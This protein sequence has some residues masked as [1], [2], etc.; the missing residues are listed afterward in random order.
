MPSVCLDI[1]DLGLI[2]YNKFL[3][4][5]EDI[6]G[7]RSVVEGE[8]CVVFFAEHPM[9]ITIGRKPSGKMF[10]GDSNIDLVKVSRGGSIT[11]HFPG[12]LMLYVIFNMKKVGVGLRQWMQGLEDIVCEG[13]VGLGAQGIERRNRGLWLGKGKIA[14]FGVGVKNWVTRFGCGV[15]YRL[16]NRINEVIYPCGEEGFFDSINRC[17]TGISR[18]D[19][20]KALRDQ[21]EA[22]FKKQ[23]EGGCF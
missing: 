19:L 15:T 14:S 18:D 12:Q 10:K 5:Q 9:V 21:V 11:A 17:I 23:S 8:R 3:E 7:C 6:A 13:L 20:I 16:D 1:K 4:L 2:E 22:F